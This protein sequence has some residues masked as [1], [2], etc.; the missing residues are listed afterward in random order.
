M[1]FSLIIFIIVF[2]LTSCVKTDDFE[3]P[4]IINI[5]INV[6]A[7]A[8]LTAVKNALDQ[9][10]KDIY[11]F[12]ENDNIIIAGYVISSD[13]AGSF[14]KTLII[15]D[16]FKDA[17]SGIEIMI[18][19]KSYFTKY[20]FGRKVFLKLAGLSIVNNQEKY[21]IG[22]LFENKI[23]EIP[24]PLLNDYITRSNVVEN[25]IANPITL[26]DLNA[27][28]IGTYVQI[29]NMQF[30]KEEL[31]KTY[32]GE[33]FDKFNGERVLEQCENKINTILSTSSFSDF[34]SNKISNKSGSISAVLTKDFFSEKYILVINDPASINFSESQRC[35]PEFFNC[36]LNNATETKTLFFESFQGIKKTADLEALNW[37]NSNTYFGNTKFKKRTSKGN[38]T[39]Q[40]SA[41]NTEENPLEAW[42]I[43]PNIELDN[44]SNEVL[45]FD[46][47]ASFDKGSILTVWIS[48]DFNGDIKN[49]NWQQ[50]DVK[51]SVGPGNTY[52]NDFISSGD[53]SLDCLVGRVNI[54]FKYLGGDPGISTTYDLDNILIVGSDM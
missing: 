38:V 25:I 9:S 19:L 44:T 20:N 33:Q 40:I 29:D 32:A 46:T 21:K 28:R 41:F 27:N 15:Q 52:V 3:V 37:V 48:T 26:V 35:D 16:D 17:K 43:T 36:D 6:T 31:G 45:T 13:E 11:T 22:Y 14:Y 12:K 30:K 10:G 8:N 5:E 39:M 2:I 4:E 34:K 42:L 54:G 23:Q 7:N 24:E 53:I 47:K 51:I 50:L 49:A 1:K 18:D